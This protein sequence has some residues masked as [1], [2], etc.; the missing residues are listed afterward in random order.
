MLLSPE[1]FSGPGKE[2]WATKQDYL[3]KLERELGCAQTKLIGP[4]DGFE[5]FQNA[6]KAEGNRETE[7]L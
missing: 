3:N 5:V 6:V 4:K 2:G 7:F 1:G